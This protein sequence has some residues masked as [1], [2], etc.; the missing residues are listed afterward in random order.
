MALQERR[1]EKRNRSRITSRGDALYS[2]IEMRDCHE[3][4]QRSHAFA[5]IRQDPWGDQERHIVRL[6]RPWGVSVPW[7]QWQA[8]VLAI[9]D[10]VGPALLRRDGILEPVEGEFNF[11]DGSILADKSAF[12]EFGLSL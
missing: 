3:R 12:R 5:F 8:G 6:S 7:E 9:I 4:Q 2:I 10:G 1:P 11:F